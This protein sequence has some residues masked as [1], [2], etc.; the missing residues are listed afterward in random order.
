[1]VRPRGI[2][3]S[4]WCAIR[5]L[6]SGCATF[7]IVSLSECSVS[8]PNL[9]LS[10]YLV[11]NGCVHLLLVNFSYKQVRQNV[12]LMT[13]ACICCQSTFPVDESITCQDA[14]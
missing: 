1:M 6:L 12:S 9:I 11:D 14:E 8:V 5:S 3:A 4:S 2:G 10:E 13:D 7:V